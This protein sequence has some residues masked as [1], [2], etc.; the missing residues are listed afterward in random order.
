LDDVQAL[1]AAAR[2][3][4][5]TNVKTRR[6]THAFCLIAR[7]CSWRRNRRWRRG[8]VFVDRLADVPWRDGAS[9]VARI[10]SVAA[11]AC[12]GLAAYLAFDWAD[13][14]PDSTCGSLVRYKG[15]GGTCAHV[16]RGRAFGAMV[17]GLTAIVLLAGAW[18]ARQPQVRNA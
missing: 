13:D 14:G 18:I 2:N 15:A 12:V 10:G 1:S 4:L 3:P 11:L 6:V 8:A 7:R 16:M 17:L 5:V 9:R